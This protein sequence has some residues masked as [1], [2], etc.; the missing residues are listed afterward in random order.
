M[1]QI[2]QHSPSVTTNGHLTDGPVIR[3][4]KPQCRISLAVA[5]R[6]LNIR[7]EAWGKNRPK[8]CPNTDLRFEFG[9]A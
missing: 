7:G 6:R 8:G 2:M 4:G 5:L 3:H 1:L 9:Q